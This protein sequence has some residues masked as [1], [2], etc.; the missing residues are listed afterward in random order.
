[1][2]SPPL[3][4]Y[5]PNQCN[6]RTAIMKKRVLKIS[7][8]PPT[9]STE[10][11]KGQPATPKRKN[12]I[13]FIRDIGEMN[14]TLLPEVCAISDRNTENEVGPSKHD[15]DGQLVEEGAFCKRGRVTRLKTPSAPAADADPLRVLVDVAAPPPPAPTLTRFSLGAPGNARHPQAPP[16]PECPASAG[17]G[18]TSAA[19][20]PHSPAASAASGDARTAATHSRALHVARGSAV[21]SVSTRESTGPHTGVGACFDTSAEGNLAGE[22]FPDREK[23]LHLAM[24]MLPFP[25]PNPLTFPP[26]TTVAMASPPECA[27]AAASNVGGASA[28]N[29]HV[30]PLASSGQASVR[31]Q[32]PA[33]CRA[34]VPLQAQSSNLL[35][36]APMQPKA[37]TAPA[38]IQAQQQPSCLLAASDAASFGGDE[39]LR[40]APRVPAPLPAHPT[41]EQRFAAL[42]NKPVGVPC[43]A[44]LF[45]NYLRSPPFCLPRPSTTASE[46]CASLCLMAAFLLCQA[47]RDRRPTSAPRRMPL[48]SPLHQGPRLP[49]ASTTPPPSASPHALLA[50]AV[51]SKGWTDR[52]TAAPAP[53][54]GRSTSAATTDTSPSGQLLCTPLP[55]PLSPSRPEGS[56]SAR[57]LLAPTAGADCPTGDTAALLVTPSTPS[58]TPARG[59]MVTEVTGAACVAKVAPLP[60]VPRFPHFTSPHHAPRQRRAASA[61][62]ARP[63]SATLPATAARAAAA[64]AIAIASARG[65][66]NGI[67]HDAPAARSPSPPVMRPAE[68]A[69]S[70]PSPPPLRYPSHDSQLPPFPATPP[71]PERSPLPFK[72]RFGRSLTAPPGHMAAVLQAAPAA[73]LTARVPSPL[74]SPS[75]VSNLGCQCSTIPLADSAGG[76]TIYQRSP[77]APEPRRVAKVGPAHQR[78]ASAQPRESPR[79][80]VITSNQRPGES[81][82]A[83]AAALAESRF[84]PTVAYSTIALAS[85]PPAAAH[86][87]P[88]TAPRT[89]GC[90]YVHPPPS[91]S[92][93]VPNAPSPRASIPGASEARSTSGTPAQPVP[94]ARWP[95]VPSASPQQDTTKDGSHASEQAALAAEAG[96]NAGEQ[97][98]GP[99]P[100]SAKWIAFPRFPTPAVAVPP[101]SQPH[102]TAGDVATEQ[103]MPVA[104]GEGG[105]SADCRDARQAIIGAHALQQALGLPLP[106]PGSGFLPSSAYPVAQAVRPTTPKTRRATVESEGGPH[107]G[108]FAVPGVRERSSSPPAGRP[109]PP[110]A[111]SNLSPRSHC[112]AACCARPGQLPRVSALARTLGIEAVAR[113][114]RTHRPATAGAIADNAAA[115]AI[116]PFRAMAAALQSA[117]AES[118][119]M[120]RSRHPATNGAAALVA[121]A[122]AD[123]TTSN[124]AVA[125]SPST[126][127]RNLV[128]AESRSLPLPPPSASRALS[129]PDTRLMAS[130]I[131][132][133]TQCGGAPRVPALADLIQFRRPRP[134][135]VMTPL[136]IGRNGLSG[137]RHPCTVA[138]SNS[139]SSASH[140]AGAW[141]AAAAPKHT[142][143]S[144]ERHRPATAEGVID[145]ERIPGS[146]QFCIPGTAAAPCAESVRA[147]VLTSAPQS[148]PSSLPNDSS[149]T[150]SLPP[151]SPRSCGA[152]LSTSQV[153]DLR[154]IQTVGSSTNSLRPLAQC[155]Q[156]GNGKL[157]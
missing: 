145:H 135:T 90:T 79:F 46:S 111:P 155:V 35:R 40:H 91:P 109:R 20:A 103:S 72:P 152:A 93:A 44:A 33:S 100:A 6:Q 63:S 147:P 25:A 133:P 121:A 115:A 153:P 50:A 138:H 66:A 132:P 96:G 64:A 87:R 8:A 24:H 84:P 98:A 68:T 86:I 144:P 26:A 124:P 123:A 125:V 102:Q 97:P 17:A 58:S 78:P 1:M 51:T 139:A 41:P 52:P 62:R 43:I 116:D 134:M 10:S 73:L 22:I 137:G 95:T 107:A 38:R 142:C 34:A 27:A 156:Q 37:P 55:L 36:L 105:A 89:C 57:L 146:L 54:D 74:P 76:R 120:A 71:A 15:S 23:H 94:S 108:T 117:I 53:T 12:A 2:S 21:S 101:D 143:G 4:I 119:L 110:S 77:E 151:S 13:S 128:S 39:P 92:P 28:V 148:T 106:L 18:V 126:C 129:P 48:A 47:R 136:H 118:E 7:Y 83:W 154:R 59:G 122:A 30:P 56:T 75:P 67:T 114:V 150:H 29:G 9:P 140:A 16:A 3:E 99:A 113:G 49:S 157:R 141:S 32:F 60:P 11:H 19:H 42:G 127:L 70:T 131:C 104:S 81:G 82:V 69:P 130:R 149:M 5:L 80:A 31:L 112:P 65:P 85:D 45:S 14:V 88:E 61:C